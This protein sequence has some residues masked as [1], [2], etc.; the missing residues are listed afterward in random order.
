RLHERRQPVRVVVG[1]DVGG[2]PGVEARDRAEQRARGTD[3]HP[4]SDGARGAE[5]QALR[6]QRPPRR[7][8][9][10]QLNQFA[11]IECRGALGALRWRIAD[12]GSALLRFSW[13]LRGSRCLGWL[14]FDVNIINRERA[15]ELVES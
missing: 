7:R 5:Q 6:H 10:L 12:F 8:I 9:H 3:G 14:V 4:C 15:A 2:D 13:V 11:F 1:R